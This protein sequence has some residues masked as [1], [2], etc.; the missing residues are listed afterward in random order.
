ML[1]TE[2]DHSNASILTPAFVVRKS[3]S[4][5]IYEGVDYVKYSQKMDLWH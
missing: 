3:Q 2:F 1:L 5:W 4:D